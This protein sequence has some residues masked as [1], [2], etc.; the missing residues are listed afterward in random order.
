[1]QIPESTLEVLSTTIQYL[2]ELNK[3]IDYVRVYSFN[4]KDN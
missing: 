2:L 4:P 3:V 1:M